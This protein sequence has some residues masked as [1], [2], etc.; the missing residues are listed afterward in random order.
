MSRLG[1]LYFGR[2]EA[3]S[4]I[5]QGGLLR[6]GFLRTA[7]YE[8]AL[9]GRKRL[10]IGRKGSGK[11]AICM[12]LAAM[13]GNAQ[14]ACLVTPDQVSQDE[15]RR[16]QLQG[17]T[18]EITKSLFWRYL[19]SVQIAK[20]LVTHAQDAHS[21]KLPD[22]IKLLIKFL[23]ANGQ[24]SDPK[25]HE[26]FWRSAQRLKT[27][28]V[29]AF[30][31]SLKIGVDDETPSEGVQT[32][33]RLKVVEAC[34][35]QASA[36]LACPPDH[37]QLLLLIDQLENV[38]SNDPASRAIITGLLLAAKH[39][40]AK[41]PGIGCVVFLRTDIYDGLPFTEKDKFRS[42]EM[43][44]EW[45]PSLLQDLA[46][47]RARASVGADLQA[48][49]LW[50]SL[51]P[52]HI[53]G[54][55]IGDYLVSRTLRRPRDLIQFANQCR[56]TAEKNGHSVIT[57]ADVEEAEI[58]FSQWKLQDLAG[59]Y[60][61]NYPYLADLFVL[62]QSSGYVVSRIALTKRITTQH[63]TLCRRHPDSTAELTPDGI[64]DVLYGVGFLG[65]ERSKQ[66]VY[67]YDDPA[68]IDPDECRF[69][70]HPCFRQALRSNTATDL[71]PMPK[72][73]QVL[74]I[75]NVGRIGLVSNIGPGRSAEFPHEVDRAVDRIVTELDD[76]LLLRAVA[77]ELADILNSIREENAIVQQSQY[78]NPVNSSANVRSHAK[79]VCG[80]LVETASQLE[81]GGMGDDGA[82]RRVARILEEEASRLRKTSGWR[83]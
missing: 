61:V 27:L 15:I 45:T 54:M 4:D 5:G 6:E 28:E 53:H 11:S 10:V 34:L 80:L 29:G 50:T 66:E 57:P 36:Q 75:A 37:P 8:A 70:V 16:F 24:N 13:P 12:A 74:S 71:R 69:F 77:T 46:V 49:Q 63:D 21:K 18:E 47:A 3:E 42:D 59:E 43:R 30:G 65:V 67:V 40:T 68:L 58:R 20:H 9:K 72:P 62:F 48:D 73:Q 39:V 78:V 31:A 64:I 23:E 2:D 83:W 44:I 51:F 56:D 1:L 33:S 55:D 32:S 35:S 52:A 60:E 14:V 82:V 76:P 22:S 17:V 19:L 41:F 81:H 7:A 25:R 26:Q 38:W 79:W